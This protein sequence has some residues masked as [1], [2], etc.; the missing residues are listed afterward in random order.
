MHRSLARKKIM[1]IK[2]L[3][4]ERKTDKTMDICLILTKKVKVAESV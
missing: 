1:Q 2:K 4:S 3:K